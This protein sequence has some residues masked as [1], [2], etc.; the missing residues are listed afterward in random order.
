MLRPKLNR[1]WGGSNTATRRD[2]GDSKYL[3]GWIAEIPTFQVLNFL[4]FKMDTTLLAQAERGFFEW[5]SDINYV[6]GSLAWDELDKQV[7]V[8]QVQ[9]PSKTLAPSKNLSQW[10]VSS[11]QIT[12]AEFDTITA[13]INA[14]IADVSGN[15]HKLTPG[16]LGAYTRAETDA[17]VATY[18]NLV[19]THVND[20]N[21]PHGTTA[22]DVGAV[23]ITGGTYTGDVVFATGRVLLD[24]A[25]N[26]KISLYSD[27]GGLYLGSGTGAV[28]V[29][30]S[31][32]AVAGLGADQSNIVTEKTFADQKA[33]VEPDY[34]TPSPIFYMPL[35][36]DMN[37][38]IGSGTLDYTGSDYY[39][40]SGGG[41]W[42]RSGQG[43]SAT[44]STQLLTGSA[45]VTLALDVTIN[46]SNSS[47]QIFHIGVGDSSSLGMCRIGLD[48]QRR[49][50]F[51]SGDATL[52][53]NPIDQ[54]IRTRVVVR[55]TA[56]NLSLYI[57]GVLAQ[58]SNRTTTPV[59]ATT[60]L[61]Y[62]ST[63]ATE[64]VYARFCNFRIWSFGLQDKQISNL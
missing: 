26:S 55:K 60:E 56:N 61:M 34:A 59:K 22:A 32:V 29:N 15:P 62:V 17:L 30:S 47:S 23:P 4:Q 53:S 27:G 7:Y 3:Q 11:V 50:L 31:G 48:G 19:L 10:S 64:S 35:Q 45:E 24:S 36:G 2:P 39:D 1:L 14:H 51:Y 9:G 58:T 46:G 43:G 40:T 18:R 25:G 13:A 44:V 8:S 16:R 41:F 42:V 49:I 20:K 5:G 37:I 6:K 21:N 28:G 63:S 57:N 52:V 38:Y 54:N 12:R 33:K